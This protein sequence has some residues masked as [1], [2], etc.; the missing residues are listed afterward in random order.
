MTCG[1][2][3]FIDRQSEL[4]QKRTVLISQGVKLFV[5]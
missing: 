5:L 3:L 4:V 1:N 2:L